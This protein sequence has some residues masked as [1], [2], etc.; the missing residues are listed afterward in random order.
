V[1]A[2]HRALVSLTYARVALKLNDSGLSVVEVP[3]QRLA[4]VLAEL[5]TIVEDRCL[6]AELEAIAADRL[7]QQKKGLA[8]K[9]ASKA[10]AEVKKAA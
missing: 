3:E 5:K 9:A 2:D 10:A 7:K 6:D 4:E 8:S 1:I